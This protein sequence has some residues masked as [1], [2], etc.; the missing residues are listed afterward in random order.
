MRSSKTGPVSPT[1]SHTHQSGPMT[2]PAAVSTRKRCG[3]HR[4]RA[5]RSGPSTTERSSVPARGRTCGTGT[6]ACSA[7]SNSMSSGGSRRSNPLRLQ[8]RCVRP[9]RRGGEPVYQVETGATK[10]TAGFPFTKTFV[11]GEKTPVYG[12]LPVDDNRVPFHPRRLDI[13]DLI[14]PP[15]EWN[16]YDVRV[17]GRLSN[18]GRTGSSTACS[19]M[20]LSAGATSVWRRRGTR[21]RF[22][23]SA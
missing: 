8:Q 18:S 6:T 2:W 11:D 10:W 4:W 19:R 9:Q 7:T 23:I 21:S 14:N 22:E 13:P 15:G 20:S 3:R 1:P 16:T 17:E 12:E 5:T